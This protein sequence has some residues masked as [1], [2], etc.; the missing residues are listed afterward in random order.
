VQ[1]HRARAYFALQPKREAGD[2]VQ[3]LLKPFSMR[4]L[5]YLALYLK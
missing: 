1:A 5:G 3:A 2:E 4:E